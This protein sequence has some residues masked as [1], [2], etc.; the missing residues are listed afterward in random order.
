MLLTI[1]AHNQR[2]SSTFKDEMRAKIS[3]VFARSQEKIRKIKVVFSDIN[4][5]KGG[6][7]QQCRVQVVLFG[8]PTVNVVTTQENIHKA[9]AKALSAAQVSLQRRFKKHQQFDRVP[10]GPLSHA[11]LDSIF[12][13][14][15][16]NSCQAA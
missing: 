11:Q 6:E 14:S 10:R 5:P 8:L 15:G 7:D 13:Q 16:D 2:I 3:A 1:H 4:G 12:N 9:L